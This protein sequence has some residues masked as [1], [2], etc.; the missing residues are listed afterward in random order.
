MPHIHEKVDFVADVFIVYNDK[1]FLRM[2]DK[3][4]IWLAV[5]GH[6]ELDEDPVQAVIRE[7]KEE[8][9]LDIELIGDVPSIPDIEHWKRKELLAPAFMNRHRV[10]PDH[11]HI[12]LTYFAKAKTDR[13]IPMGD[14]ISNE[15]KWV[16][17][18]EL[19]AMDL[20]P[21]IRYYAKK[22]LEAA[23]NKNP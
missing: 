14:D 10:E 3:H 19:E 15:W 1:V 2:H 23:R 12:S 13:I 21:N 17:E 11:E 22:A 18:A 5:G 6:I 4:K 20:L 7:A 8:S 9:G 16:S